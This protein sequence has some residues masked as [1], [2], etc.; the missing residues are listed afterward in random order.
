[1]PGFIA[2]ALSRN[3]HGVLLFVLVLDCVI[4][5]RITDYDH[6]HEHE[7]EDEDEGRG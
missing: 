6:D 4:S 1:M 3:N 7:H 5:E 2:K